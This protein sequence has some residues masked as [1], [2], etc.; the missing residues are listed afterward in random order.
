ML[1]SPQTLEKLRNVHVVLSSWF[2]LHVPSSEHFGNLPLLPPQC[3]ETKNIHAHHKGTEIDEIRH[4]NCF[5]EAFTEAYSQKTT[6]TTNPTLSASP[7]IPHSREKSS[8]KSLKNTI[9]DPAP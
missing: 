4:M 2:I 3:I 9:P 8:I 6:E 5:T 7:Q 1:L